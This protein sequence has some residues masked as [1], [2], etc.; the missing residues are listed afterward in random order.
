MDSCL[1][2]CPSKTQVLDKAWQSQMDRV[3][4]SRSLPY[5]GNLGKDNRGPAAS[6]PDCAPQEEVLACWSFLVESK[7]QPT[8]RLNDH[9]AER[10][11]SAGMSF[12]STVSSSQGAR[13]QSASEV[14]GSI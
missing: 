13:A 12:S 6:R 9:G 10:S 1:P 3:R 5:S 8:S 4:G 2:S 7:P 11:L 14:E